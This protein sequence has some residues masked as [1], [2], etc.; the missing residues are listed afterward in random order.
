[1]LGRSVAQLRGRGGVHV[2]ALTRSPARADLPDDVEVV[3]GDL[4]EPTSLDDALLGVD[5]VF[6]VF[7]TVQA[8][9]RASELVARMAK[10]VRRIVYLSAEG[11]PDDGDAPVEGIIGSHAAIEHRPVRYEELSRDEMRARIVGEWGRSPETADS[12]LDAW[13]AMV[14]NRNG[15]TS[16]AEDLTGRPARSFG[17]WA[18]D[19]VA[20]FR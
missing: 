12:T 20:D 5:A 18:A 15:I 19:H 1:M 11:V 3:A 4:S 9:G 17:T 7:P 16:T 10:D 8:D 2:R 13:A 6:L 14:G